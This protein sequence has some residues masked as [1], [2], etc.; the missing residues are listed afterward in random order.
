MIYATMEYTKPADGPILADGRPHPGRVQQIDGP[1]RRDL[2]TGRP[3]VS[4]LIA[5]EDRL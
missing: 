2:R 1:Q 4:N 5:A 3:T